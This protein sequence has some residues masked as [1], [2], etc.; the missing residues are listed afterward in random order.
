MT[1]I[2][3]FNTKSLTGL[4]LNNSLYERVNEVHVITCQ[5]CLWIIDANWC[6]FVFVLFQVIRQATSLFIPCMRATRSCSTSPYYCLTQKITSNRYVAKTNL[7]LLSIFLIIRIINNSVLVLHLLFFWIHRR[8]TGTV[9]IFSSCAGRPDVC[10][11]PVV[12]IIVDN[13]SKN[14][15][16]T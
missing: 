1:Y 5:V 2:Q 16:S 13:V 3:R 11:C 4:D 8:V 12:K 15:P 9:Q 6:V 10:Q 7:P 14:K